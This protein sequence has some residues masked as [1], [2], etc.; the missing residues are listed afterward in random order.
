MTDIFL[1]NPPANI[2]A[3]IRAHSAPTPTPTRA[4]TIITTTED[5]A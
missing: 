2:E 4:T 1:G 3:W 5:G